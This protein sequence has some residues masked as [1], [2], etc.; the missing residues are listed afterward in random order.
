MR[1]AGLPLVALSAAWAFALPG[2]AQPWAADTGDDRRPPLVSPLS[3]DPRSTILLRYDCRSEIGRREVALFADGV[4]RLREA[5]PGKDPDATMQGQ[6][7]R[8]HTLDPDSL[9]AY[10]AR[11][12]DED[13]SEA[14]VERSPVDG[15]WV[16]RC[17]LEV[18][19]EGPAGSDGPPALRRF[20]FSRYSALPL[21][22][23]RLVRVAE[24]L[25]AE[26]GAR[27][28]DGLP[29]DYEPRAG[30]LLER[31]D[32]EL[33]E[34]VAYTIDGKGVELIGRSSPLTIYLAPDTLRERFVR[35]VSRDGESSD[36]GVD[37]PDGDSP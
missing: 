21:S 12:A 5:E 6:S 17:T 30:D 25:A 18:L 37:R 14:E 26:A 3:D 20:R 15:E 9:A 36:R 7:M 1:R 32:G 4:V 23:S 2:F 16:E 19:R 11:I 24:D 34:V 29:P 31:A 27:S 13:L 10:R 28:W 35:L 22:L 8:L 33:F